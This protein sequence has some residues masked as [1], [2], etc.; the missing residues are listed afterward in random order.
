M[1]K[2]VESLTARRQRKRPRTPEEAARAAAQLFPDRPDLKEPEAFAS[3]SMDEH[4]EDDA[5]E[6]HDEK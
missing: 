4:D 5:E 1:A 2:K 3:G 6:E